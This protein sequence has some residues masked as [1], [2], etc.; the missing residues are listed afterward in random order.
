MPKCRCGGIG[1]RPGLKIPWENI[2]YRFDPGHRHQFHI[3]EWSN[4]VARRAH[5]PKVVGSNPASATKKNKHPIGCLFFF[6]CRLCRAGIEPTAYGERSTAVYCL[7]LAESE[8]LC[9]NHSIKLKGSDRMKQIETQ[10]LEKHFIQRLESLCRAKEHYDRGYV[11]KD[12]FVVK[13]KNQ[14][15]CLLKHYARLGRTHGYASEGLY[16][17]YHTNEEGYVVVRYDFR[18]RTAY[19]IPFLMALGMGLFIWILVFFD[20]FSAVAFPWNEFWIS[21]LFWVLGLGGLLIR[22]K[23]ERVFLEEHL[24]KICGFIQP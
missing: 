17:Q 15:F 7:P 16:C 9:Y 1:R 24:M 12:T 19:L 11:D 18:L 10:L 23:Q 21:V 14:K 13:R 2:P 3:A 8:F 20:I 22:S 6:G 5:N 4:P